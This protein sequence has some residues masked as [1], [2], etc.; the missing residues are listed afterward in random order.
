MFCGIIRLPVYMAQCCIIALSFILFVFKFQR[1]VMSW[2]FNLHTPT[3]DPPMSLIFHIYRN[4]LALLEMA[5][6]LLVNHL[7]LVPK[8]LDAIL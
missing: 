2:P 4:D 5:S 7:F 6:T 8:R 3:H 1:M